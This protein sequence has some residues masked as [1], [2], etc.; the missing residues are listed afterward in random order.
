MSN[1]PL[2]G[3]GPVQFIGSNNNLYFVPLTSLS[4]APDGSIDATK[5]IQ[6]I[7][8]L[9]E[10]DRNLLADL[11]KEQM[12]RGTIAAGKAP[13][14][15]EAISFQSATKGKLGN[16]ITV[17][18]TNVQKDPADSENAHKATISIEVTEQIVFSKLS[19]DKNSADKNFVGTVLSD[20]NSPGLVKI[21][22]PVADPLLYPKSGEYVAQAGVIEVTQAAS[23]APSFKVEQKNAASKTVFKALV[24]AAD[25]NQKVF[26]IAFTRTAK[27]SAMLG[28]L[29]S[30]P[31]ANAMDAPS[32]PKE[33]ALVH[34]VFILAP[35]GKSA[36]LAI[37]A[38]GLYKLAGGSDEITSPAIR[39]S[40]T[41]F[42]NE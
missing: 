8:S 39:S 1:R 20:A 15:R 5:W 35:S 28:D 22:S 18:I 27:V 36:D 6:A 33:E 26:S 16:F 24:D 14:S 4:I 38:V 11:V 23:A 10:T 12:I 32:T 41:A 19:I 42:T 34:A 2:L 40:V 7:A 13:V 17:N 29:I 37:P 21:N 25:P 9:K 3:S 31:P 30:T